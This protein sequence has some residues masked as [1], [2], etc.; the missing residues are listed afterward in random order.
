[1][2]KE[3]TLD[4]MLRDFEEE[5]FNS[6][7]PEGMIAGIIYDNEHM[8]LCCLQCATFTIKKDEL[9]D[10]VY[11]D[12]LDTCRPGYEDYYLNR[13]YKLMWMENDNCA[14]FYRDY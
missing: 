4:D 13:T 7:L 3:Y 2:E 6:K 14:I 12:K 8:W 1:M 9:K 10:Y 11:V 5:L